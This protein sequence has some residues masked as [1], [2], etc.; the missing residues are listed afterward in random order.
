MVVH[1]RAHDSSSA[2]RDWHDSI[3]FGVIYFL[4]NCVFA[5]FHFTVQHV[6]VGN[7]S[8]CQVLEFCL[9]ACLCICC[10][11][12][13][14]VL[15]RTTKFTERIIFTQNIMIFTLFVFHNRWWPHAC[16]DKY[17]NRLGSSSSPVWFCSKGLLQ[18]RHETSLFWSLGSRHW[19]TWGMWHQTRGRARC[20][21]PIKVLSHG[22]MPAYRNGF[23]HHLS[24]LFLH[25]L[26]GFTGSQKAYR[27]L[28]V[29][30]GNLFRSMR[31]SLEHNCLNIL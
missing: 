4:C 6:C 16:S 10:I 31:H 18:Y 13:M 21:P 26:L 2:S 5:H 19:H 28:M 15:P 12:Y 1:C 11:V 17:P 20:I 22:T 3:C 30:C 14:W 24:S 25:C 23:V 8:W 29:R 27:W 9:V 7:K